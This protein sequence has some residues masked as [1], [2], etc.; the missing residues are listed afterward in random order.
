MDGT[1]ASTIW[2]RR[3]LSWQKKMR[4]DRQRAIV[5]EGDMGGWVRVR[6]R[7]GA[8]ATAPA[9]AQWVRVGLGARLSE[10]AISYLWAVL[11]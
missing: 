8:N 4:T 3:R 2:V 7:V 1:A 6:V 5:A 9:A 10:R 11:V